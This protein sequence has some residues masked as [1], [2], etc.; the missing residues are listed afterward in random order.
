[1]TYKSSPR[2][3]RPVNL[4]VI[5][6]A[7]GARTARSL[8][9]YFYRDDIQASSHVGIDGAE[10]LQY[11]PYDRAAW[12]VR[13]GNPVSDNAELCGFARWT[14]AQWLSTGT[15]DGCANPRAMLDRTGDWVRSRILARGIPARKITPAEVARWVWGVIGHVD[16]TLGMHDGTHTDP[17][18]NFP[19]DYVIERAAQGAEKEWDEM[20]SEEEV[21]AATH[22]GTLQALKDFFWYQYTDP[23]TG[24]PG[25]SSV[26][27]W[28]QHTGSLLSMQAKAD[29]TNGKLDTLIAAVNGLADA[30]RASKQ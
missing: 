19:W 25:R 6:T 17:G 22:A 18:P 2:G 15:V 5:H 16:W 1:M 7:E 9:A 29:A 14:R 12:T 11:V 23:A 3:T 26:N 21:R 28:Q 20:A 13:S 24:K 27:D 30:I 10:T 8:G 4:I